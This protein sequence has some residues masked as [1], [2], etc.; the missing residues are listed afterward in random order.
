MDLYATTYKMRANGHRGAVDNTCICLHERAPMG[1]HKRRLGHVHGWNL[2]Y[3]VDAGDYSAMHCVTLLDWKDASW[4]LAGVEET[5]VTAMSG[6]HDGRTLAY[7][8]GN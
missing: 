8:L 5:D 2:N 6:G 3:V 4:L 1:D 7:H